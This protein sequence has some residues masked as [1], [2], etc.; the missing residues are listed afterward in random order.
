MISET[1]TR[2]DH[3]LVTASLHLGMIKIEKLRGNQDLAH[4]DLLSEISYPPRS[5]TSP[6]RRDDFT[7]T[8]SGVLP[9]PD[10]ATSIG[11]VSSDPVNMDL[12]FLDQDDDTPIGELRISIPIADTK[13]KV[14]RE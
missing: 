6:S 4:T 2:K 9:T 5:M 13:M 12:S 8:G 3:A 7:P 10:Q 1:S 11:H 14:S